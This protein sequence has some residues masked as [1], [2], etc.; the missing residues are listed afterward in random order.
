[1]ANTIQS[2]QPVPEPPH[3]RR[4]WTIMWLAFAII[5]LILTVWGFIRAAQP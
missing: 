3:A 4:P 2:Q 1:M 5:A